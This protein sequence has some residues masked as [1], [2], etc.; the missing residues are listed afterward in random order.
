[1]DVTSA[2]TAGD[3]EHTVTDALE[4]AGD[5]GVDTET[6]RAHIAALPASYVE[7]VPARAVVRHAGM[8]ARPLSADELRT[9]VSCAPPDDEPVDVLD[10][11]AR[12]RPEIL[13]TVAGILAI[14]GGSVR[15]ARAFTRNDRV[16]VE[17]FQVYRPVGSSAAWWV[18]VEGDLAE[19]A[20]GRLALTAR[21]RRAAQAAPAA[22]ERFPVD[23]AIRRDPA[24][25]ESILEVR[26]P[27]RV[28]L[29]FDIASALAELKLQVVAAVDTVGNEAIDAFRLLT[30]DGSAL[31]EDHA[32][33]VLL[34]VG[35]ALRSP[36]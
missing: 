31:D 23:V 2:P 20:V 5:L 30:A 28:G 26:A 11:V 7:W 10:V 35:D 32:A 14:H 16:A 17:T 1:M 3:A 15:S 13:A 27:D 34:A 24:G 4:L 29:L 36:R 22:G 12:Q 6:V 18:A 21:V 19:A 8:A 25:S 33:E 9:R